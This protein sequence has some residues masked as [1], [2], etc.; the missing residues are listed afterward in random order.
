MYNTAIKSVKPLGFTWETS[1]PF[2]FCVHHADAY[3]K[4][5]DEMGPAASLSGRNLGQDFEP[6]DGWRMYHGMKFP[7]FQ[8]IRIADLKP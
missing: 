2:L 3:P 4:G 5:N 8:C 6:K 7:G 1:D